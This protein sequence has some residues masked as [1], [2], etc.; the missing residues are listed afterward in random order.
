[1]Q[2]INVN[3]DQMIADDVKSAYTF[4][5]RFKGLM[6]KK[7]IAENAGLHISPCSSIHTFFMK[8][9]ID[10]IYLNQNNEIVGIEE[11]LEPGKIGKRFADA[12][13]VI[14]LPAGTHKRTSTV[15]GQK[16]ALQD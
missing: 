10:I 6:M 4:M 16:V 11:S 3:T 15:I 1:M 12:K 9:S 13:S 2:L 8:F 5:S 14:E 7:S